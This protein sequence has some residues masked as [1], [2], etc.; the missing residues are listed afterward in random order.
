[1]I[2]GPT[3][4]KILD[5]IEQIIE[6][7]LPQHKVRQQFGKEENARMFLLNKATFYSERINVKLIRP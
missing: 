4:I 7:S 2:I 5:N 6:A 1:M 3:E